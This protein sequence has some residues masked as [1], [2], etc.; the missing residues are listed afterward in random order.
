VFCKQIS[1]NNPRN[2]RTSFGVLSLRE[3]LALWLREIKT[4]QANFPLAIRIFSFHQ[5]AGTAV[6]VREETSAKFLGWQLQRQFGESKLK[7]S[8]EIIPLFS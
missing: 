4:N 1:A 2:K 5:L 8:R 7:H 6:Y 3:V